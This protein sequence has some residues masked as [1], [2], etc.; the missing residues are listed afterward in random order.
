MSYEEAIVESLPKKSKLERA[1]ERS[2]KRE[3][4]THERTVKKE[5]AEARKKE[6]AENLRFKTDFNKLFAK[7]RNL[8][9]VRVEGQKAIFKYKENQYS[10]TY[11]YWESRGTGSDG[12][13]M[14]GHT[15]KLH[16]DAGYSK[17]YSTYVYTLIPGWPKDGIDYT[18]EVVAGLREFAKHD[19][20]SR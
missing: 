17:D 9:R 15:W 19:R 2:E 13:D 5:Y 1:V 10:I 7:L 18:K 11:D 20:E 14:D 12:V 16:R 3:Q 6:A 8:V 4:H